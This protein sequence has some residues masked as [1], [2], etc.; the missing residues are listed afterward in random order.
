MSFAYP[1]FLYSLL[2]LSLAFWALYSYGEKRKTS[3][4]ALFS[5]FYLKNEGLTNYHV[6]RHRIKV[7]L[8]YVSF[9]CFMIALARPQKGAYTLEI[10]GK[11]IDILFALD[12][13]KSMLAQ[14]I[15]P[16]R[17]SRAKLAIQDVLESLQG[18]RIGLI[19]FAGRAFLECPLT[20]DYQAFLQSLDIC[21]TTIISEGGTDFAAAIDQASKAFSKE[22]SHKTLI[23]ISD[24]ED[25][26]KAGY[27]RAL[28]AK[29]EGIRIYTVGVGSATGD[30]I[31]LK[32]K[33]GKLDYLKDAQGQVVKSRLDEETLMSMAQITGGFYAPLGPRGEGL[34]QIYKHLSQTIPPQERQS[35]YKTVPKE[36]FQWPLG[37]A[38]ILLL[39]ETLIPT[40]AK[41]RSSLS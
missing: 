38:L 36:H 32:D 7:G 28:A 19:A 20:L 24:G 23:L 2:P 34:K 18:D 41:K 1:F 26:E 40:Y 12:T 8:L 29:E 22:D 14:D 35:F 6:V 16:D 11:S 37:L 15:K 39:L 25:L 21:D 5:Q 27:K 9:V 10:Q 31:P 3:R 17:L 33:N 13:S 30:I 4:K